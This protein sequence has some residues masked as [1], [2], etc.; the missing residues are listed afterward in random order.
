[1][2]E[3][4]DMSNRKTKCDFWKTYYHFQDDKKHENSKN[5]R[6]KV[7]KITPEK[8]NACDYRNVFVKITNGAKHIEGIGH[9]WKSVMKPGKNKKVGNKKRAEALIFPFTFT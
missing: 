9:N 5:Y 4:T 7:R 3:T 6:H 2:I 1:M 8:W